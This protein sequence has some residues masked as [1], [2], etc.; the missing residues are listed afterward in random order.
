MANLEFPQSNSKPKP[1]CS[2]EQGLGSF[3]CINI[4]SPS[5]TPYSSAEEVRSTPDIW[6][7]RR[8]T[9]Q[10]LAQ[11]SHKDN[12]R[13][14]FSNV[15]PPELTGRLHDLGTISQPLIPRHCSPLP[16]AHSVSAG[17]KALPAQLL[18]LLWAGCY[19][20]FTDPEVHVIVQFMSVYPTSY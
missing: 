17:W 8:V 5:P 1:G 9:A 7:E 6:L 13:L 15:H 11:R 12:R 14:V 10:N 18:L 20:F 2:K 4:A 3:I 19:L 16:L